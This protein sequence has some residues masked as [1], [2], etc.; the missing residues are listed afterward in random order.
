MVELNGWFVGGWIKGGMY[1]GC[2]FLRGDGVGC[3]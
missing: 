3:G 1:G 2:E